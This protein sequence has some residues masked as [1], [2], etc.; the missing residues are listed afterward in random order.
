MTGAIEVK[1]TN[2]ADSIVEYFVKQIKIRKSLAYSYTKE[3]LFKLK[4]LCKAA[5]LN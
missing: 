1:E 5:S 4:S 2:E 3:L